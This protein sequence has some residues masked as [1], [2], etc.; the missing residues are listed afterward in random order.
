MLWGKHIWSILEYGC[1]IWM[2]VYV[3]LNNFHL[4]T[5]ARLQYSGPAKA[6]A[7][8]AAVELALQYGFVT[9]HTSMVV[10]KP[11]G[12]DTQVAHK[13]QEGE[14]PGRHD[15]THP[16]SR[17][18]HLRRTSSLQVADSKFTHTLWVCVYRFKYTHLYKCIQDI[19][20]G[21]LCILYCELSIHVT[22]K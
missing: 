7:K 6:Q 17:P 10:T 13:P 20:T 15:R 18:D 14:K 21:N 2:Q 11:E 16:S 3:C 1:Y 19:N 12:E 5:V 4:H 22:C 8:K 9:P